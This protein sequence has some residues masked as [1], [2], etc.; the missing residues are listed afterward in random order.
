MSLEEK[1]CSYTYADDIEA[2]YFKL[3]NKKPTKTIMND[4]IVILDYDEYGKI[5]GVE[6]LLGREK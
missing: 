5:I 3:E 2:F 4:A 1:L 6:V